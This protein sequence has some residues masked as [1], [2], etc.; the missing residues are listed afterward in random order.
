MLKISNFFKFH[1]VNAL[2][3]LPKTSA[4]TYNYLIG[5]AMVYMMLM[6]LSGL[7]VHKLVSIGPF[8]LPVGIFT[9]PLTYCLSNVIT[10]V[11][12][13]PIGRNLMWWFIISSSVF[14]GLSFIFIHLP[15]P[16]DFQYQPYFNLIF[17]SMPRVFVA[18]IIGTIIGLSINNYIVSKFK[19]MMEGNHYWLRSIISTCGGEIT[20]TLIAYPIMLLGTVRF[21]QLENIIVSVCIF[22]LLTTGLFLLPEC[23]LAQ[24]LKIKEKINVFDYGVNYSI[25]SISLTKSAHKVKL[26]VVN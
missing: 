24:Y 3:A 10:E 2:S 14:T 5:I 18:G 6:I 22:K 25:F 26:T 20:Y 7:T 9:T 8:L 16:P 11:Y 21:V 1:D 23:L 4:F 15:S 17:G 13:Y 12:G 19:V